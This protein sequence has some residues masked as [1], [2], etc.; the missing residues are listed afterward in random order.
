MTASVCPICRA[1]SS[2]PI[3]DLLWTLPVSEAVNTQIEKEFPEEYSKGLVERQARQPRHAALPRIS[4]PLFEN[5]SR[6]MTI[7]AESAL[8]RGKA[9]D[10]YL[11]EP[12]QFLAL[13]AVLAKKGPQRF[14]I[15][16]RGQQWGYVAG[17]VAPNLLPR[18]TQL[19]ARKQLTNLEVLSSLRFTGRIGHAGSPRGPLKIKIL[20]VNT[21]S[22]D[23][24]TREEGE[25][26]DGLSG[27][28]TVSTLSRGN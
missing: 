9:V 7:D 8:K 12:S 17:I 11:T 16:M 18:E 10:I 15:L 22:V 1:P 2:A 13:A 3:L 24:E 28:V 20:L 26:R 27:D 6:M 14:G 25:L 4:V 19:V 5:T 21:F 23:Q